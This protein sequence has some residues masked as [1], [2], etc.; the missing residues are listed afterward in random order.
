MRKPGKLWG[1]NVL[2]QLTFSL[3]NLD[4]HVN[5]DV[6]SFLLSA[7]MSATLSTSMS[8]TISTSMSANYYYYFLDTQ[9]S[10]APNHVSPLVRWLV[11][12]TFYFLSKVFSN[13]TCT[14]H[15]RLRINEMLQFGGQHSGRHG[16]E[17]G[18]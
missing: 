15:S 2:A 17:H 14:R 9:V 3:T 12:H 5:I 10:L 13:P 6:N 4:F 8:D 1:E 7:T 16:G 18:G 11:G